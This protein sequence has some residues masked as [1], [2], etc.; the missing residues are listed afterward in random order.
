MAPEVEEP[1]KRAFPDFVTRSSYPA[2][3][4]VCSSDHRPV[5]DLVTLHMLSKHA[6]IK[7]DEIGE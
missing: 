2:S 6:A 1:H 5:S 3:C 4:A 7:V